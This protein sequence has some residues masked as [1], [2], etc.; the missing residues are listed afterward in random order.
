MIRLVLSTSNLT[1]ESG[2]VVKGSRAEQTH[3]ELIESLRSNITAAQRRWFHSK[4]IS[5]DS[6]RDVQ[7]DE[8]LIRLHIQ[9]WTTQENLN[10]FIPTIDWSK[11]RL[12]EERGQYEIT[13]K[14]FYLQRTN[15][16]NRK[17]YTDHA[18]ELV[19]K[20][21]KVEYID[22]LVVAFP[23]IATADDFESGQDE[24]VGEIGTWAVV[25]GLYRQ[26]TVKKL[27]VADFSGDKLAKF[28]KRVQIQP[29]V[30]QI[31]AKDCCSV[32]PALLELVKTENIELLAHRDSPDIFPC[33]LIRELLGHGEKG[34][35][36]LP[37][38]ESGLGISQSQ[39]APAW[40]AKYVAVDRDRG[41]IESKGYFAVAELSGLISH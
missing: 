13:V 24:E 40:V 10:Y 36:I 41:V 37:Q 32:D 5:N 21:L 9:G 4:N 1:L 33:H 18:I 35:G 31:K 20:L 12:S 6:N 23:R 3:L 27:G 22:L 7:G 19:S 26:G 30:D 38:T 17:E 34:V 2:S 29:H 8:S 16:K 15:L 25:E 14:L 28:L 11:S 39:I